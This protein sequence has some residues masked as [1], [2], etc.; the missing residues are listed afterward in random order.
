MKKAIYDN[1]P[2]VE[3]FVN[4]S[5]AIM[6]CELCGAN[7]VQGECSEEGEWYLNCPDYETETEKDHTS[8]LV[9]YEPAE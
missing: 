6:T 5:G 9:K 4:E 8:V 7:L 3:A 2:A 1:D